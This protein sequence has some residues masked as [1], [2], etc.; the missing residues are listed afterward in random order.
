MCERVT[1]DGVNEILRSMTLEIEKKKESMCVC[2]CVS[3]CE[4][5]ERQAESKHE[6]QHERK[7]EEEKLRKRQGQVYTSAKIVFPEFCTSLR[8]HLYLYNCEY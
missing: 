4:M 7:R 1:R 3:M 2:M 8:I 5:V 6:R